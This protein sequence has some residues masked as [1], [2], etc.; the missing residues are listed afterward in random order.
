MFNGALA[1]L[2]LGSN[3]WTLGR[4]TYAGGNPTTLVEYDG[5][6][7]VR[8]IDGGGGGAT[9][10]DDDVMLPENRYYLETYTELVT[11][12]ETHTERGGGDVLAGGL[13]V[14]GTAAV[15]DGPLPVGDVV[16]LAILATA[17]YMYLTSET[18]V[19]TT[20]VEEVTRTRVR[21]R[22]LTYVTYTKVN[23]ETGQ[24]YAGRTR[25]YGTPE[26]IVAAR[27]RG[28]T[29]LKGFL[30]AQVDEALTATMPLASR[31]LDPSYQAI[32]GRE[33]QLIDAAGGSIREALQRGVP[34]RSANLIR[35]VSP[36]NPLGS[37]YHRAASSAFGE[38]ASYTGY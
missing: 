13:A 15:V 28:H 6:M 21:E 16:G 3:P 31:H 20:R 1:D 8:D 11:V 32:R 18:S 7:A 25:G 29:A 35:G 36:Y 2:S 27:D 34:T 12:T 30:P 37:V 38:I 4:Y 5:H 26:Q 24:I 19:T 14:A 22:P 17:A 10:L 9:T 23:S 33:Q